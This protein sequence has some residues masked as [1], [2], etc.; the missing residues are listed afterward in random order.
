MNANLILSDLMISAT[1][2]QKDKTMRNDKK[3]ASLRNVYLT[4]HDPQDKDAYFEALDRAFS[5]NL[6]K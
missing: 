3:L 1:N 5:K 2:L 4:T 6:E